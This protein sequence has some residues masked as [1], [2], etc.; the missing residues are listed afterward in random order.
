MPWILIMT[1]WYRNT[2]TAP[3]AI[4]F[5]NEDACIAVQNMYAE[6]NRQYQKETGGKMAILLTYD[7]ICVKKGS[8]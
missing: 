8:K 4:E 6:R 1:I 3:T 5:N 2:V 7:T